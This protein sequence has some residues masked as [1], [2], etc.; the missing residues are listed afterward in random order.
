MLDYFSTQATVLLSPLN[1]T[2]NLYCLIQKI[3]PKTTKSSK[4]NVLFIVLNKPSLAKSVVGLQFNFFGQV[5]D[6]CIFQKLFAYNVTKNIKK[7]IEMN[8]LVFPHDMTNKLGLS[9]KF[10]FMTNSL[11]TSMNLPSRN[12]KLTGII[13]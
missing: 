7:I 9:I 2:H 3:H 12:L 4:Q 13:G 6:F 10:T 5:I 11:M 1:K 8:F